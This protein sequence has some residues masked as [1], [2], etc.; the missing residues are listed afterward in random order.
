V[1]PT[2][3]LYGADWSDIDVSYPSLAPT[4]RMA[5]AM[6]A[7]TQ[8]PLL[9]AGWRTTKTPSRPLEGTCEQQAGLVFCLC[10]FFL[11]MARGFDEVKLLKVDSSMADEVDESARMVKNVMNMLKDI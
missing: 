11:P 6:A 1:R 5:L 2:S 3:V 7:T 4:P 9:R 8:S 10:F